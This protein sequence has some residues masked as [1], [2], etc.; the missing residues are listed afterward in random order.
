MQLSGSQNRQLVKDL[1]MVELSGGWLGPSSTYTQTQ[2][3]PTCA[4]IGQMLLVG[5]CLEVPPLVCL[6]RGCEEGAKSTAL[7]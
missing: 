7:Q 6:C 1:L 2:L 3:A 5:L 4:Y